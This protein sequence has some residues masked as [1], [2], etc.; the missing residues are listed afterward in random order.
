M[1]VCK[2]LEL[3]SSNR[4]VRFDRVDK[5]RRIIFDS[6]ICFGVPLIFMALRA[7][8]PNIFA[9]LNSCN[10]RLCRARSPIQYRREPWLPT[11]DILFHR[12]HCNRLVA[13]PGFC[14]SHAF[15]CR[16][17]IQWRIVHTIVDVLFSYCIISL[18]PPTHVFCRS[19]TEFQFGAHN[20]SLSPPYGYGCDGNFVGDCFDSLQPLQQHRVGFATLDQLAE[21]PF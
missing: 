16:L 20:P 21:C 6:V 4:R 11:R 5:R 19:L 8:L 9:L 14:D 12:G 7:L 1:C 15:L 2:H 13:T 10:H 18:H 17:V 3:V